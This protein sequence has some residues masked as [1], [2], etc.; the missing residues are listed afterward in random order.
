MMGG[1]Q[2]MGGPWNV[3]DS[4]HMGDPCALGGDPHIPRTPL[5]FWA[6]PQ[7]LRTPPKI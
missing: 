2:V 4:Q 6:P 7:A 3:G 5:Q 1:P